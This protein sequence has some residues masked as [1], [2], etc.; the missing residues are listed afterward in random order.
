M[1]N[2]DYRVN[3]AI[4]RDRIYKV[5]I[6]K[7]G[8]WSSFEPLKYQGVNTKFFWNRVRPADAP[9]GICGCPEPCDGD[10]DGSAIGKCK[11]VTI[12][13]FRT[14]SIII[15][16]ANSLDQIYEA[17]EFMN[18]VLR[19]NA[20]V[21]LRDDPEVPVTSVTPKKKIIASPVT[22]ADVLR[23]KIR[24]SPRNVVRIS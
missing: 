1:I 23:Q 13:P 14:G 16:G 15:N 24:S 7:Y 4:R 18:M 19:E 12:S 21:I 8:L 11:R 6:E 9:P 5:L 3:K 10:G 17:Y 22:T 2:S 20:D